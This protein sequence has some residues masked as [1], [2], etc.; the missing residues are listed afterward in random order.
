MFRPSGPG[1]VLA[2]TGD[3]M[4]FF[5]KV[6]KFWSSAEATG[7]TKRKSHPLQWTL[8][9]LGEG[10]FGHHN[11]DKLVRKGSVSLR[12]ILGMVSQT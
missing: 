9:A 1:H 6:A 4:F 11:G 12:S 5:V 2:K 10:G 7:G 8:R 3:I